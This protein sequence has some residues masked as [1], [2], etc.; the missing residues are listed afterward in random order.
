MTIKCTEL[1]VSAC[2]FPAKGEAECTWEDVQSGKTVMI[3]FPVTEEQG[4]LLAEIVAPCVYHRAWPT[5]P[6]DGYRLDSGPHSIVLGR[7]T[8]RH[9]GSEEMTYPNLKIKSEYIVARPRRLKVLW[10]M[11]SEEVDLL[12]KDVPPPS[13]FEKIKR[14]MR[15]LLWGAHDALLIPRDKWI[16]V[17][18]V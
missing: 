15:R 17:V 13:I 9:E 1:K 16:D 12:A 2:Y 11:G 6:V 5:V 10:S 18:D 7:N 8:T 4:L 14:L 3:V